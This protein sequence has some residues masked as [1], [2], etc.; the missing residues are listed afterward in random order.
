MIPLFGQQ[1]DSHDP[2]DRGGR[3]GA[4]DSRPDVVPDGSVPAAAAPAWHPTWTAETAGAGRDANTDATAE[5]E[6]DADGEADTRT[7]RDLAEKALLKRLRTRSLSIS[8]ARGMLREHDLDDAS[9]DTVIDSLTGY[10][11][12][13]DAALA[14]QLVH[15]GVDRKGQGRQLIA[16]SLS[17][18][19]VPR[20]IAEAALRA[21]PDDDL[22][23]AL[24][25]A[26][27]KARSLRSLDRD[28]ALRRLTG[29]LARR[30]YS[31]SLA[32]N[33]ART[34]LEE[35]SGGGSGVRFR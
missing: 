15:V 9:I 27:S 8:E 19:G 23:R 10:G 33:A 3:R 2:A 30:G 5:A 32:L 7:R 11:Y 4:A 35:S 28:T 25:Y 6:A 17:R 29:Q 18:R 20:D 26:R 1:S 34:A 22:E 14:E 31:G 12:L 21:L 13:D 24:E 16:Q